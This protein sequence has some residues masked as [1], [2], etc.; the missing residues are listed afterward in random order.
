MS[1]KFFIL[2][3]KNLTSPVT[4][5]ILPF[6]HLLCFLH[7]CRNILFIAVD[8]C[9]IFSKAELLCQDILDWIIQWL[10]QDLFQ[11][12]T[13]RTYNIRTIHL[14]LFSCQH[15]ITAT[16][17]FVLVKLGFINSDFLNKNVFLQNFF[18]RTFFK[19]PRTKRSFSASLLLG[20]HFA[21]D[22][23][24]RD[25]DRPDVRARNGFGIIRPSASRLF[26]APGNHIIN[27]QTTQ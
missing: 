11:L 7:Y 14:S 10:F 12:L 25:P 24:L 2:P 23:L 6:C 16:F 15:F 9:N 13:M 5:I 20:G 1:L 21:S 4:N 8:Y 27:N 26:P 19:V 18:L 3:K 22:Q 17:K